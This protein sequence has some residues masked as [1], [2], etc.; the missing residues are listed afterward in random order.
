MH[1]SLKGGVKSSFLGQKWKRSES[2]KENFELALNRVIIA[3]S[4][5]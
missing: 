3:Y 4:N 2:D 1:D 5:T